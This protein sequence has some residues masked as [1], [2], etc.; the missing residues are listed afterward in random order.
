MPTPDLSIIVCTYQRPDNL[1]RVLASIAGQQ[2]GPQAIEV[3]VADDGSTDETQDVVKQF[4]KSVPFPVHF[5]THPHG[6]FCPGKARNE[7]VAA[8]SGKYLLL[9]DGDCL[10]PS[11]HL[12]LQ[13][14]H[15]QAG[16]VRLGDCIRLDERTSAKITPAIAQAGTF[17][18]AAPWSERRRI[19][20]QAAKSTFYNLR[21]HPN[22]PRLIAN[23]LALAR[24]D[25]LRVNGFDENYVGWGAEDDDF[26][27]RLRR[28]GL[29]LK[30]ILWWTTCYHLWHPRVPSA[31]T[32]GQRGINLDYLHRNFHLVRCANGVIKR[33]GSDLSVRIV[34]TPPD[35]QVLRKVLP[36]EYLVAARR[37]PERA[38]VEVLFAPGAG[39]FSGTADC[40]VLVALSDGAE[41]QAALKRAHLVLTDQPFTGIAPE[42]QFSLS[43]WQAAM[44][45]LLFN[46]QPLSSAARRAA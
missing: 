10:L 13:M 3:V 1:R 36:T 15:R 37:N 6:G 8:S 34:G 40:N 11:N 26:G 18:R 2:G 31:P 9:L 14:A 23:N 43:Q 5:T 27:F 28:V 21:Y 33:S 35:S 41:T 44:N 42:R 19:L 45:L 46:R 29:T 4:Q 7:G 25:F 24:E 22:R 38:E 39:K 30:T 12:R 17:E 16:V 20:K 32:G